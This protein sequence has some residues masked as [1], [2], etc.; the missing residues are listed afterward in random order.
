MRLLA[1]LFDLIVFVV[2]G[3]LVGLIIQRLFGKS[4]AFRRG[5]PGTPPRAA[6]ETRR[7][8]TVRD[9]VCGMFVSTELSHPL[10]QNGE[11]LHFCSEECLER[12]QKEVLHVSKTAG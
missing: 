5:S 11:T 1:Y 9:P 2:V 7:G 4:P 10:K 6:P 3:R 12:Y 8:E